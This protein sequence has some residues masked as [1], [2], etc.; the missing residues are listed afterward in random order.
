MALDQHE[1]N[2]YSP[3]SSLQDLPHIPNLK[4]KAFFLDDATGM[5][6]YGEKNHRLKQK[7]WKKK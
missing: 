5:K 6:K 3:N 1:M 2:R 7:M 4:A